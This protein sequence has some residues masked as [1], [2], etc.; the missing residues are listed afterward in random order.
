[1]TKI[2]TMQIAQMINQI[3]P[4]AWIRDVAIAFMNIL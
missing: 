3:N 4:N 2:P 1:M